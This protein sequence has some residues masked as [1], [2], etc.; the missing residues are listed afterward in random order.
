MGLQGQGYNIKRWLL[1]MVLL[2]CC[3]SGH[4][5]ATTKLNVSASAAIVMDQQTGQVL[6]TKNPDWKRP[7]ASLTKIVT[8]IL[9][10]EHSDLDELVAISR[11]A[12]RTPGSSM[13]LRAGTTYQV[14]DLLYGLMLLSGNDAAVALAEHSCGSMEEFV[15]FMNKR[16]RMLGALNTRFTNPHGLPA[17]EHYSTAHDMALL[18]RH[19]LSISEFATLVASS[20]AVIPDPLEASHRPIYNKNRLLWEFEGADGVKTGYTLAAGRCLVASATRNGRQVVVVLLDAPRLWEDAATL[21]TYGL[22]EYDNIMV[23]QKGQDLGRIGV[24]GGL[25]STV[26]LIS[27]QDIWITVPRS[28]K[29]AIEIDYDV[30]PE[31]RAPV[32]QWAP[33]GKLCVRCNDHLLAETQILAGDGVFPRNWFGLLASFSRRLQSLLANH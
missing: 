2:V 32:E 11:E 26:S 20:K 30:C 16:A 8:A 9:V 19:A 31:V 14:R 13:Y 24:A 22:E 1:A 12:A 21:L 18:A 7:M 28:Q 5:G 6:W 29:D 23:A 15:A 33:L 3:F 25:A 17:E 27:A 4:V 10:L